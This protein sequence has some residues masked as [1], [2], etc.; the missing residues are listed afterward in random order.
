MTTTKSPSNALLRKFYITPLEKRKVPPINL[1]LIK[2]NN[3]L[4]KI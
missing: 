4:I 2:H 1:T 3:K